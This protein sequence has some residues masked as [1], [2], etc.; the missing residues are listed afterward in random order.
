MIIVMICIGGIAYWNMGDINVESRRLSRQYIPQIKLFSDIERSSLKNSSEMLGYFL[1]GDDNYFK[2]AREHSKQTK[3]YFEKAMEL[4]KGSDQ[5]KGLQKQISTALERLKKYDSLGDRAKKLNVSVAQARIKMESAGKIFH[6]MCSKYLSDQNSKLK[7]LIKSS[8]NA[9]V[10][11]SRLQNIALVKNVLI[12]GTNLQLESFKSQALKDPALLKQAQQKFNKV[13]DILEK[14][15]TKTRDKNELSRLDKA[16]KALAV[17]NLAISNLI[18]NWGAL[19]DV[20]DRQIKVAEGMISEAK[21]NMIN[22]IKSSQKAASLTE[23]KTETSLLVLMIGV[24]I[25]F[26]ISMILGSILVK[27]ITR[28]INKAIEGLNEGADQIATA[29]SQVSSSSQSLAEGASEQAAAVE[30]TSSSLEELSSMTKLNAENS[31]QANQMMHEAGKTVDEAN[32]SMTRLKESMEKINDASTETAKIIK[33]IDEVT[34]QTNLL[35]LNA[36]VEAARAGE[37]GAG[38]AVVA[39]EVRNLAMRTAEA[40]KSTQD[41]IEQNI[42]YIKEGHELV[43]ATD[44]AFIKVKEAAQKAAELVTEISSASK[45]QAE[46]IEQINQAIVEMDKGTQQVA[47]NAE[48]SAS[49]SEELSGQAEFLRGMVEDLIRL[50]GGSS[51]LKKQTLNNNHDKKL[52]KTLPIKPKLL[53]RFSKKDEKKKNSAKEII[54]FDGEEDFG[55]F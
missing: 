54:P 35:A 4:S 49:A 2:R 5:L 27:S 45:E 55:D 19:N 48:E 9:E 13:L 29:A 43:V 17:Y 11:L 24:G 25:A 47:A 23:E 42:Q 50:V 31:G 33:T 41:I 18:K 28:P 12:H 32:Q 8:S 10:M 52:E 30:E 44:E 26:L 34:F 6:E 3:T 53:P 14:L 51:N 16:E 22:G 37:A 39:D 20:H 40:A 15:K 36:A 1:T 21:T 46:G 7:E 38:F